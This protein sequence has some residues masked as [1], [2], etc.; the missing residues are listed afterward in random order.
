MPEIQS[1]KMA[2]FKHAFINHFEDFILEVNVLAVGNSSFDNTWKEDL[3][4]QS[5]AISATLID[6]LVTVLSALGKLSAEIC[7]AVSIP[8]SVVSILGGFALQ[9]SRERMKKRNYERAEQMLDRDNLNQEIQQMSEL[10]AEIY[11]NQIE[12]GT[13][14][15][16]KKLAFTIFSVIVA[17]IK[18]NSSF[19]FDKL[20][21]AYRLQEMMIEKFNSKKYKMR[22]F[23]N[24]DVFDDDTEMK[25]LSGMN[26]HCPP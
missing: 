1:K 20:L 22:L 4:V 18:V 23:E 15:Q 12:S 8:L 10:L 13:M 16:A 7:A 2:A 17:E 9:K 5:I 11:S 24:N 6:G 25:E 21:S 19:E 14:S 3:G 26:S